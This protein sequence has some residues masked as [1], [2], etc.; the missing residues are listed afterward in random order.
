MPQDLIATSDDFRNDHP[1]L[2]KE[3]KIRKIIFVEPKTEKLH[4]YSK[5][6]LP[7]IGA[8][9]LATIM[10]NLGHECRSY[11]LKTNDFLAKN[12]SADLVC[13]STITTT[14]PAAYI[15]AQYYQSRNIPVVIGG[16][17]VTALP[18]EAL[19]YADY[20]IRGEGEIPL[21]ELV[22]ALN[23]DREMKMVQGLAWK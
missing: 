11:Y 1:Q 5:F 9:L 8:V 16:P 12:I 19:E 22:E 2:M 23:G 13:I 17:H 14:A 10:R 20:V 15:I 4:I 6:E 18:E 21:P 7:R 3:K